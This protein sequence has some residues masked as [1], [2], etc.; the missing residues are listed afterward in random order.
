MMHFTQRVVSA[1]LVFAAAAAVSL[2]G[3]GGGGGGIAGVPAPA[4]AATTPAPGNVGTLASTTLAITIPVPP[5]SSASARTPAYVSAATAKLVFTVNGNPAGLNAA[6]LTYIGTQFGT[7]TVTLGSG[8]CP[9]SGPWTCTYTFNLPPATYN[10]TLSAQDSSGNVLSQETSN[11]VIAPAVN[12]NASVVLIAQPT[13]MT[14]AT[15]GSTAYLIGPHTVAS[16]NTEMLLRP[17]SGTTATTQNY[18]VV[19]KDHAGNTVTG[20][21]FPTMTVVASGNTDVTV[22]NVV[23]ASGTSTP[24][25]FTLNASPSA[26]TP[27]ST[28]PTT[29]TVKFADPGSNGITALQQTFNAINGQMFAVNGTVGGSTP[30]IQLYGYGDGTFSQFGATITGGSY[31]SQSPDFIALDGNYDLFIGLQ[32]AGAI[33]E[34]YNGAV[35]KIPFA[36]LGSATPAAIQ[37]T[38]GSSKLEPDQF[39]EMTVTPAGAVVLANNVDD[40]TEGDTGNINAEPDAMIYAQAGST[41]FTFGWNNIGPISGDCGQAQSAITSAVAFTNAA[42]NVVGL[43]GIDQYNTNGINSDNGYAVFV[44]FTNPGG[45][46]TQT[47]CDVP[48]TPGTATV[49]CWEVDASSNVNSTFSARS[50]WD[51]FNQR[52]VVAN[53]VETGTTSTVISFP[54][55]SGV[56]STTSNV[57]GTISG[58]TAYPTVLSL[59]ASRNGYV[60][61]PYDTTSNSEVNIYN[62]TSSPTTIENGFTGSPAL[63]YQDTNTT[64]TGFI[65]STTSA[66]FY[67]AGLNSSNASLVEMYSTSSSTPIASLNLGS[68]AIRSVGSGPDARRRTP[69]SRRHATTGGL[70]G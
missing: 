15:S 68:F 2:A 48:G 54:A 9:G 66:A 22:S 21:G 31:L 12:N 39:S 41:E 32:V 14:I 26:A 64:Q 27:T 59:A 56:I 53:S 50:A 61:V 46:A 60:G 3:C 6:Q 5:T 67:M 38:F 28:T 11:I 55:T 40:C 29:I 19:L 13:S 24:Y 1:T 17:P 43:A 51:Q 35:Y 47:T 4:P 37:Y 18:T 65:S 30:A 10:L 34:P 16:G 23:Q 49:A 7:K 8:N 63:L 69:F 25:S 20:S 62:D 42:S 52:Y 44:Y 33:A 70:H 58:G 57:L 45:S 36:N